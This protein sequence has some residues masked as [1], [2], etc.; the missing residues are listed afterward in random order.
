MAL[1][2]WWLVL[3]LACGGADDEPAAE[4]AAAADDEGQA[5]CD[6]VNAAG[7]V[8]TYR[9]GEE[10]AAADGCNACVCEGDGLAICTEEDC[11]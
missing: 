7:E 8:V 1:G 11:G 3:A 5:S 9:V 2:A 6:D 4:P 10:W